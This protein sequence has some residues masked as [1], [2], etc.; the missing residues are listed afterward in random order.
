M[1][2]ESHPDWGSWMPAGDE[3]IQELCE[4]F[5][6]VWITDGFPSIED[7]LGRVPPPQ[8]T[9]LLHCLLLLELY[10][11]RRRNDCPDGQRYRLRFPD[12]VGLVNAAFVLSG[13]SG[14]EQPASQLLRSRQR[15]RAR[16]GIGWRP[17]REACRIQTPLFEVPVEWRGLFMSSSG[18]VTH[19]LRLLEQGDGRAAQAL[20]ERYFPKLVGLARQKLRDGP[21]QAADEED[22]ALSVFD[23]V[24]RRAEAGRLPLLTDRQGLWGLL[25]RITA[26]KA[27]NQ[28]RHELQQ[29][30]DARR[31]RGEAEL[32]TPG[33]EGAALEQV[34]G[35]EPDPAFAAAV[36]E[37]CRHLLDLLGDA[38]LR[39]IAV[40]KMEGCTNGEIAAELACSE[41]TVERRLQLI[42]RIWEDYWPS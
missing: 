8:R 36:A 12:H 10:Y 18:S 34:V 40:R 2:S 6:S 14:G 9:A 1:N 4:E 17:A 32:N 30:R 35:Q 25:I 21:R 29:K 27:F 16:A 38:Q 37:E 13:M 42:R 26:R 39:T 24:C 7:F 5:E 33:E 11:R 23:T 15:R 3:R 31:V 19:W 41:P 20:W 28:R 22:V